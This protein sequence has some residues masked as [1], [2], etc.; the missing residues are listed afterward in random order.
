MILIVAISVS[1][2]SMFDGRGLRVLRVDTIASEVEPAMALE[3]ELSLTLLTDELD[4]LL[5]GE[6][7][8]GVA[9]DARVAQLVEVLACL[10]VV[11]LLGI[12]LSEV[13][14]GLGGTQREDIA[15]GVVHTEMGVAVVD[16]M[17]RPAMVVEVVLISDIRLTPSVVG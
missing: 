16:F 13:E 4:E 5:A 1:G 2:E 14:I 8:G 11:A 10:G 12:G 17:V 7:H 6:V 9:R 15:D 3:A